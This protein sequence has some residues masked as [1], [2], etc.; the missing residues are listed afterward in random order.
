MDDQLNVILKS[1]NF[2][3]CNRLQR[4]K[5]PMPRH[6]LSAALC[7]AG[8]QV[9]SS[10]RHRRSSREGLSLSMCTPVSQRS[11]RPSSQFPVTWRPTALPGSFCGR[12]GHHD[13]QD[14][15]FMPGQRRRAVR[16]RW[17]ALIG[18]N[19]EGTRD[20]RRQAI[21]VCIQHIIVL[22][23]CSLVPQKGFFF[24]TFMKQLV[25]KCIHLVLLYIHLR[26]F[27]RDIPLP[28]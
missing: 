26:I 6:L 14:S 11:I 7:E 19:S 8:S 27:L 20:P 25:F 18:G 12:G 10:G 2:P 17:G 23:E 22:L 4:V 24:L 15:L 1:A 21:K 9:K 3:H 13:D 5:R 28:I 16:C